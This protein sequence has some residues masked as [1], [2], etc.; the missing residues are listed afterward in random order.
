M[1]DTLE[2]MLKTVAD[3]ADKKVDYAAMREAILQK[4]AKEKQKKR[5]MIRYGAMAAAAVILVGTG[6]MFL[7]SGGMKSAD[8]AAPESAEMRYTESSLTSGSTAES[9]AEAPEAAP[10]PESDTAQDVQEC[11]PMEPEAPAASMAPEAEEPEMNGAPLMPDGAAGVSGTEAEPLLF[12]SVDDLVDAWKTGTGPLADM[13]TL[14]APLNWA[15]GYRLMEIAVDGQG[16]SYRCNKAAAEVYNDEY[17][18]FIP[19]FFLR[20]GAEP[21]EV[22]V[23]KE[24]GCTLDAGTLL[25][26][27]ETVP[28]G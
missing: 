12:Y 23:I 10:M 9:C 11:A 22:Q 18:V 13:D 16:I 15:E 4:A 1:A 2:R 26:L 8:L 20:E 6:S 27:Q 5:S 28:L 21:G 17:T 19:D 3:E 7:A 25:W 14:L 24:D